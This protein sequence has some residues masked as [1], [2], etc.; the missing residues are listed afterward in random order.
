VAEFETVTDNVWG[1]LLPQIVF[2]VTVIL[3]LL[4]VRGTFVI[5]EILPWPEVIVQLLGTFQV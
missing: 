5:I 4:A 3:P 1:P 2:A